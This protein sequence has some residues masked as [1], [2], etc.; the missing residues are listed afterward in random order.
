MP[1][2]VIDT[3]IGEF[4][5][6]KGEV[7]SRT[8]VATETP[9]SWAAVGLPAGLSINSSGVISGTITA[10]PNLYG[11]TITATNASGS[12][13]MTGYFVIA[14]ETSLVGA[15]QLALELEIE[16]TTKKVRVLSLPEGIDF[17]PPSFTAGAIEEVDTQKALRAVF[18]AKRGERIP[19]S[20]TYLRNGKRQEYDI[21]T[22][23]CVAKEIEPEL[24]FDLFTGGVTKTGSG[25]STRYR[26][27]L[28]LDPDDWDG[29]FSNN[30]DDLGT[31]INALTEIRTE[32]TE[33]GDSYDQTEQE[34]LSPDLS[35]D[36][37]TQDDVLTFTGLPKTSSAET[38]DLDL[39][40]VIT[41]DTSQSV[42]IARTCD[43]LWNGT[44][45][46]VSNFTGSA[47][48]SG[49]DQTALGKWQSTLTQISMTG[50]A[51]G[52]VLTLRTS[53]TTVA[54]RYQIAIDLSDSAN[55]SIASGAIVH[56]SGVGNGEDFYA[57]TSDDASQESLTITHGDV[58][59]G[60]KTNFNALP[61]PFDDGEVAEVY[62]DEATQEIILVLN[63]GTDDMAKVRHDLTS[64]EYNRVELVAGGS[65]SG[66]VKAQ[67]SIASIDNLFTHFTET[68][69]ARLERS[70][71]PVA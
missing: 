51:S 11:Y 70:L 32:I 68:F 16:V 9:T 5:A 58:A 47:S 10:S 60:I 45:Y 25:E 50:N 61:S 35:G 14:E 37:T 43:I 69:P 33:A 12:D 53:A 7:Y 30:E 71:H 1:A 56:S 57:C 18:A 59:S 17:G 13:E 22:I 36:G 49:T 6:E 31:A 4:Y 44:S 26:T 21:S 66:I 67:L 20:I 41:S 42:S 39:D 48:G 29:V 46:E 65:K 40:L 19:V 55:L 62:L 27:T 28:Y 63:N 24:E 38:F 23:S 34:T 3:R 8:V 2:P 54:D 15:D 64:Y 52:L